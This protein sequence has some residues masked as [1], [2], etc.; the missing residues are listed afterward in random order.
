MHRDTAFSQG[1]IVVKTSVR[2]VF[3]DILD[4]FTLDESSHTSVGLSCQWAADTLQEVLGF[5]LAD[6][7]I[8]IMINRHEGITLM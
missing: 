3:C 5:G 6:S 8:L 1:V 4:H 7:V 2:T